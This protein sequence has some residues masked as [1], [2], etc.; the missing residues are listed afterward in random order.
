MRTVSDTIG[1]MPILRSGISR[2]KDNAAA[3]RREVADAAKLLTDIYKGT[4]DGQLRDAFCSI[5]KRLKDE[6]P[7]RRAASYLP[8]ALTDRD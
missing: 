4:S 7:S 2:G 3:W 6:A 8:D 5:A 1:T